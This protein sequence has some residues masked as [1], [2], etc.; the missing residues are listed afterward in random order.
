MVKYVVKLIII[1]INFFFGNKEYNNKT[2]NNSINIYIPSFNNFYH[3][4]ITMLKI[5]KKGY[6]IT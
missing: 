1:I 4:I 5:L 6:N 2:N 3:V